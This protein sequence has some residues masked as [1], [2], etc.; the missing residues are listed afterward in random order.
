MQLSPPSDY[1]ENHL[2]WRESIQIVPLGF[3]V[4][5]LFE[6]PL[7]SFCRTVS[8]I[9]YCTV[10]TFCS[11]DDWI[12]C[13]IISSFLWSSALFNFIVSHS[14]IGH[15]SD[16]GNLFQVFKSCFKVTCNKKTVAVIIK[17]FQVYKHH[18][19]QDLPTSVSAYGFRRPIDNKGNIWN[20][21]LRLGSRRARQ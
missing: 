16:P 9:V 11:F 3:H 7:I 12:F 10:F 13:Y 2:I 15:Y 1:L 14:I 18:T 8:V 20:K 5:S 4:N 21:F 17:Y 6:F 19:S